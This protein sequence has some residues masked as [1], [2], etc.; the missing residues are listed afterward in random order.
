MT[1]EHEEALPIFVSAAPKDVQ[2]RQ[3]IKQCARLA[4]RAVRA[5]LRPCF[6]DEEYLRPG[7]EREP[8]R[9]AA[10]EEARLILLL[11]S[12]DFLADD[13]CQ[14]D[15]EL[16]LARQRAGQARVV[17]ISVRFVDWESCPFATLEA[18]PSSAGWP[19]RP[20]N[21]WSDR[22]QGLLDVEQGLRRLISELVSDETPP[23]TAE[24]ESAL[25]AMLIDHTSFLTDRLAGFVGRVEELAAIRQQI[26]ELLPGGGYLAISGQAGQGKSSLIARLVQ[27]ADPQRVVHH[28]LPLEPGPE[29]QVALLR[30]LLARLALVY[31]LD[32]TPLLVAGTSRPALQQALPRLLRSLAERA[33]SAASAVLYIDG[34]DQLPRE[35]S[36]QRDLSFLPEELPAGVVVVLGMRSDDTLPSLRRGPLREYALPPLSRADFALLLQRRGLQLAEELADRL[37]ALVEQNALYLDLAARELTLSR[38]LTPEDLIRRLSSDPGSLF[39]VAIERLKRHPLWERAIYP[40]LG[41][42]LAAREPL[43]PPHLKQLLA[44]AGQPVADYLVRDALQ[45]LGGLLVRDSAQRYSLFHLKFRDYLRQDEEQPARAYL[46]AAEEEAHWHAVLAAWCEQGGLE[47]LWQPAPADRVEEERRRYA[48]RHLPAHL[49]QARQWE[50]LFALLDAGA[51]GQQKIRLL[52][53]STQAYAQDLDLGRRAAAWEG[54]PFA[55]ALAQVPRLWRYTLL[56]CSLSSQ[57][58]RYPPEAFALLVRLGRGD[59][60]RGLAELVTDP[61]LKVEAWI[62]IASQME[63]Q[64]APLQEYRPLYQRASDLA[65]QGEEPERLAFILSERAALLY[66]AGREEPAGLLAETAVA[67]ASTVREASL[68]ARTLLAVVQALAEVGRWREAS[69]ALALLPAGEEQVEARLALVE[70]CAQAG[71]DE[72]AQEAFRELPAGLGRAEALSALALLA[73]RRGDKDRAQQA[74]REAEALIRALSGERRQARAE[75][76]LARSLAQAGQ[77]DEAERVA[78]AIQDDWQRMEALLALAQALV[79]AAD[80]QEAARLIER[81]HD[82]WRS[83]E[84]LTALSAALAR[85][86]RWQEA[87]ARART[88]PLLRARAAAQA[89]RGEAL[90]QAGRDEE[91]HACWHEAEQLITASTSL[92][93]RVPAQ[94]ALVEALARAGQQAWARARWQEVEQLIRGLAVEQEQEDTLADL[95]RPLA[96]GQ[97]WELATQVVRAIGRPQRRAE[98]LTALGEALARA[99]RWQE[100][101][102]VLRAIPLAW[103]RIEALA[104]LARACWQAGEEERAHQ[105]WEEAGALV[106]QIPEDWEQSD[107]LQALV[108][109]QA[110]VGRW[111]EAE[112]LA[113]SIADEW[114]QADLL[115]ILAR[116]AAHQQRWQEA[117]RV[118]ASIALAPQRVEALL[119]LGAALVQAGLQEEAARIWRE[120][121]RLIRACETEVQRAELLT[122]L[123]T[124]LAAAG[125]RSRAR[126][127]WRESEQLM[128]AIPGE[129]GQAEALVRLSAALSEAQEWEEV[130]RVMRLIPHEWRQ[131]QVQAALG[132]ALAQA[133]RWQ[134][135]ERVVRAIAGPRQRAEALA[136]LGQ[137]LAEAGRREQALRLWEEARQ[138]LQAVADEHE[139]AAAALAL[140]RALARAGG[141]E[142][143]LRLVQREWCRVAT[144]EQALRLFPLVSRLIA[145]SPASGAA[146]FEG[147]G[148]VERFLEGRND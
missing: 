55:E 5:D 57:A 100:A 125:E 51:Y 6:S 83:T 44:Q 35:A 18:L 75:T 43:A 143:L 108:R 42:L 73:A 123:G 145:L 19:P 8:A 131:E 117:A 112:R 84:A 7:V 9:R 77:W 25:R 47:R 67:L 96:E 132:R 104:G 106:A 90:A 52:D 91:A 61:V 66:R 20:L 14:R 53:P 128:L 64:G 82:P 63:E 26:A 87:A 31:R 97:Q 120:S 142:E 28:F 29:Y 59:E 70:A 49:F 102:T 17:P 121:E 38:Q 94:V 30:D 32:P 129:G 34:L 37:Y 137:L 71:R 15:L 68:R 16:A 109:E 147:F 85:A 27:D 45:H 69:Q 136:A 139:Q 76:A 40:T 2:W 3:R 134:E 80:W 60:A 124:A 78:L 48:R 41:L 81:I 110:R 79:Q 126:Q 114:E 65:R 56:R 36:G 23:F 118:S 103:G 22:D 24:Q 4:A 74:W 135:A 33:D 113:R 122:A 21:H 39:T 116:E 101:E 98:A 107:A 115:V 13:L 54:W 140:G 119:A 11:I 130:E 133:G 148:W 1:S 141:N 62:A 10:L 58:D 111:Q 127:L 72:E 105:L 144:R 138:A 95:A 89:A 99:A 92:D 88:I 86:G 12:R 93:E 46:F 146:C 50:R